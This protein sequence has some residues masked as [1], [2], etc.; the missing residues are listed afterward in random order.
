VNFMKILGG[1]ARQSQN[2]DQLQSPQKRRRKQMQSAQHEQ[3]QQRGR[4]SAFKMMDKGANVWALA[5]KMRN[6]SLAGLA[7]DFASGK[8]VNSILKMGSSRPSAAAFN[9]YAQQQPSSRPTANPFAQY[10]PR[11]PAQPTYAPA[12]QFQQRP[13]AQ[14]HFAQPP[15]HAHPQRPTVNPFGQFQQRPT[16]QPT[17]APPPPQMPASGHNNNNHGIGNI[18]ARLQATEERIQAQ[19]AAA[20]NA[21]PGTQDIWNQINAGRQ[22]AHQQMQDI[23]DRLNNA[24]QAARPTQ[25]QPPNQQQYAPQ[26]SRPAAANTAPPIGNI[27]ARLQATEE[28]IQAQNA[29]AWNAVPGAQN[30]WDQIDAAQQNANQQ[31]Q[32]VWAMLGGQPGP[33]PQTAFARP[34]MS[35]PQAAQPTA[36]PPPPAQPQASNMYSQ[37]LQSNG[38]SQPVNMSQFNQLFP[39]PPASNPTPPPSGNMVTGINPDIE[40]RPQNTPPSFDEWQAQTGRTDQWAWA[41]YQDS[42]K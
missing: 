5:Q 35:P 36:P 30:V 38:P 40:Y 34:S 25:T 19:N 14:P 3:T 17:P 29:A 18:A 37:P 9:P 20:W 6:N 31:M 12:P 13:T 23:G 8:A 41:D 26:P 2:I 28:R 24:P 16:A 10:Q 7:F 11:P 22:S 39:A 32:D 1:A 27:A 4:L 33:Q 15:Q 42:I 21:V